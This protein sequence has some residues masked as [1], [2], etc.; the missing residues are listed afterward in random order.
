MLY[1]ETRQA[2]GAEVAPL[3]R[4]EETDM[5]MVLQSI[6]SVNFFYMWI[7][8]AT[9]ILLPALGATVC[10]C[11]GVVNLGLEGIMLMSA[12]ADALVSSISGGL[13]GGILIRVGTA[14]I[15]SLIFAY[16]HL[17]KH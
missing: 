15:V 11:A 4:M 9:P 8:V 13:F 5:K 6:I 12:L 3:Q 2:L 14:V 7:R 17:R 10:S 1:R 16:F